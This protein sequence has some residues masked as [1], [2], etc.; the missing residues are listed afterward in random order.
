MSYIKTAAQSQN[1]V[2]PGDLEHLW[3][4]H[5]LD[6]LSP[7]L[8]SGELSLEEPGN[9]VDMGSGAGFPVL[10][11]AICL[12]HWTFYAIEPRRL[13]VQHLE[14]SALHLKLS[15]LNVVGSKAETAA[16]LPQL[17]EQA[18]IVSARAVGK[19]P[20]DAKRARPFLNKRGWF[21]TYK[22]NEQVQGIDGYHPLSYVRYRLPSGDE[23]RTLVLAPI[24]SI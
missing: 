14:N 23:P 19:I 15:N 21:L 2:S 24:S 13:R 1:L 7:L 4:R 17:R 10:P 20:D 11:L 12:P 22:H 8:W 9:W 16:L 5:I 18:N 3:E 6:S